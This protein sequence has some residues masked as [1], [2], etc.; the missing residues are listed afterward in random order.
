MGIVPYSALSFAAFE[1]LKAFLQR[2]ADEA[3]LQKGVTAE[4]GDIPL[5]QRLGSGAVSGMFAQT[6][7]YP[8][9]VVRRRMQVRPSQQQGGY[10]S[11]WQALRKIYVREGVAGGL[12]KGLTLTMLKGPVQSAVGFTVN[13]VTKR[14][15]RQLYPVM[16]LEASRR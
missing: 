12:Y 13:D 14:A 4:K 8:L 15:L 2:R 10:Q 7:T 6:S 9:H 5:T 1:T 3:A 11:T 16:P